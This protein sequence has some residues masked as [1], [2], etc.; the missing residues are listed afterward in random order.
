MRHDQLERELNLLLLLTENRSHAVDE[1]C[2]RVGISRRTCYYYLESFRDW[3]FIIEK[4]GRCYSIDRRSPFFLRLFDLIN[5]TDSEALTM[6]SLLNRLDDRDAV[7]ERIRHKLDR[8]YDLNLLPDPALRER[9]ARNTAMV[10]EAIKMKQ[11]AVLKGYSSPHSSTVSDRIVEPFMLL[12]HGR[13]LRAYELKTAMNKTFK[14]ARIADVQLIDLCWEHEER[15]RQVFTD[16]F[17]F[18]GE[19][20]HPV[21]LR[22]GQL[23]HNLMEE[24]YPQSAACMRPD[25][26]RHWIF[27]TDVASYVGIGRFV[28]GLTDD[29]EVLG[30]E[31]F[32]AYLKAKIAAMQVGVSARKEPSRECPT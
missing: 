2:S 10:Y 29:I 4:H 13:E 3:G 22:L 18:S 24:E 32:R 8:Y 23:A 21:R 31:G 7:A 19:Q 28:L 17:M 26:D 5:F 25:G 27:E 1:I 30:D 15:H 20:R 9:A 14:I 6:L 16:I 12:N 11:M